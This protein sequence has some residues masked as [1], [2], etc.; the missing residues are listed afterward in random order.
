VAT[1]TALF[2]RHEIRLPRS[3]VSRTSCV[4][5]A[6]ADRNIVFSLSHSLFHIL[7]F[8]FSLSHRGLRAEKKSSATAKTG[9]KRLRIVTVEIVYEM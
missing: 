1:T 8:T 2:L 9:M 6:I 3:D 5:T 4:T 7:S